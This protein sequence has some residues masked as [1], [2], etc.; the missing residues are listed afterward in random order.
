MLVGETSLKDILLY[1]IKN[2]ATR[3]NLNKSINSE[4]GTKAI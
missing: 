2:M 1:I 4:I 3:D